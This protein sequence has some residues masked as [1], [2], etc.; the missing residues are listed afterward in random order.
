[1]TV[2]EGAGPEGQD[3]ARR[4]IYESFMDGRLSADEATAR[5]LALDVLS[6][7]VRGSVPLAR[8]SKPTGGATTA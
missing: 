7:Q 2:F 1:M 5:L 8:F 6:R 3:E 4:A